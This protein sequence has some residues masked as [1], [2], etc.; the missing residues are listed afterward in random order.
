[1]VSVDAEKISS[2]GGHQDLPTV[3]TDIAQRIVVNGAQFAVP[4]HF[5]RPFEPIYQVGKNGEK[6]FRCDGVSCF[7]ILFPV[8]CIFGK[9]DDT[10]RF[11]ILP[12]IEELK[13]Y[14]CALD[15]SFSPKL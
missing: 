2:L 1:M 13:K 9:P 7:I 8:I 5:D 6:V 11:P 14:V 3:Q 10:L 15:H 12:N 4:N